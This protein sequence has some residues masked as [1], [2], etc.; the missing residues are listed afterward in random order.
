MT[1]LLAIALGGLFGFVL[2]RVGAADP[3]KIVGLLTLTDFHLMKAIMLG[4]GL[5][6][7]V[8]FGG[9][10]LGVIEAGHLS[11]KTL[12]AGVAVGGALLGVGW[13]VAGYCPGT[14][15]V[16]LGAGRTDAL[17]FVLGGLVGAGL[18][19]LSYGYLASSWLFAEW[20]DGKATMAS[21][22]TNVIWAIG[23]GVA[24]AVIAGL[25]PSRAR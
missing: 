4:I 10:W 16:G 2:Q 12:Y 25:L 17:F 7:A 6:S 21:A 20:L 14:G 9:L 5:A 3:Q 22:Q 11:I 15:L 19:T 8:L 13:A 18:F 1:I 23:L 24:F